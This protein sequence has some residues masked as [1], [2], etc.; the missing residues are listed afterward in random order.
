MFP[1]LDENIKSYLTVH[2]DKNV[3]LHDGEDM[4]NDADR[5]MRNSMLFTLYTN[6]AVCYI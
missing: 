1:E 3:F 6:M 2:N 5:D 4:P